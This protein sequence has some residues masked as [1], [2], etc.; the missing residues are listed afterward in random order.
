VGS[1]SLSV[2]KRD[3]QRYLISFKWGRQPLCWQKTRIII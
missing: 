2:K 1:I 3:G